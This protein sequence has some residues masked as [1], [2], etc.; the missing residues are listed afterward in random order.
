M[1]WS[2]AFFAKRS[3]SQTTLLEQLN[4]IHQQTTVTAYGKTLNG[5]TDFTVAQN[6]LF[7]ALEFSL[8]T[9]S[10]RPTRRRPSH[11]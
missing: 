2:L 11:P 8:P 4:R 9:T 6:S 10:D 7:A 5:L 3:E 1:P